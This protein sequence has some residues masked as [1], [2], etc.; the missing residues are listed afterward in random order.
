MEPPPPPY[1]LEWD[2]KTH[3]ADIKDS[4]TKIADPLKTYNYNSLY[5]EL[6]E[7]FVSGGY[8]TSILISK[9]AHRTVRY[10]SRLFWNVAMSV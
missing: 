3:K 10:R 2:T 6:K 9:D 8:Y 4:L 7:M 1:G 5:N